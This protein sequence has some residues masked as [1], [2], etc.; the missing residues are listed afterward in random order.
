MVLLS[1]GCIFTGLCID[2]KVLNWLSLGYKDIH[3]AITFPLIFIVCR[4]IYLAALL[5]GNAI[6]FL[7][8]AYIPTIMNIILD[9]VIV[10]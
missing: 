3:R 9:L 10:L 7:Y 8:L 1:S 2:T 5:L 4:G 6:D